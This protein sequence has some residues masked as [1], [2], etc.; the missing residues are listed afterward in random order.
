METNGDDYTK[1]SKRNKKWHALNLPCPMTSHLDIIASAHWLEEE[2]DAPA[3]SWHYLSARQ[4]NRLPSETSGT[5]LT[6]RR[7]FCCKFRSS[8]GKTLTWKP[9]KAP[10]QSSKSMSGFHINSGGILNSPTALNAPI[11]ARTCQ[12]KDKSRK[13]LMLALWTCAKLLQLTLATINSITPASQTHARRLQRP[14]VPR[15]SSLRHSRSSQDPPMGGCYTQDSPFPQVCRS[16]RPFPPRS[17]K[18][19]SNCL[20]VCLLKQVEPTPHFFFFFFFC[21]SGSCDAY[22]PFLR[23]RC[24]RCCFI[25]SI[26]FFFFNSSA[27]SY[28]YSPSS[29]SEAPPFSAFSSSTP[30]LLLILILALLLP[31][32]LLLLLHQTPSISNL[33]KQICGKKK[34]SRNCSI[35]SLLLFLF[36]VLLQLLCFFRCLLFSFS[37]LPPPT[38]LLLHQLPSNSNLKKRICSPPKNKNLSQNSFI[39]RLFFFNPSASSD[40]YYSLSP[41]PDAPHFFCSFIN[42][43]NPATS[44]TDFAANEFY[45]RAAKNCLS[46]GRFRHEKL[47]QSSSR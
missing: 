7:F 40:T 9:N 18:P 37:C 29:A 44:Q 21:S 13:T 38:L 3:D 14:N 10:S 20:P 1:A 23:S 6:S 41:A 33:K 43:I 34:L 28:P 12:K 45:K 4:Q 27:S 36:F 19:P 8:I 16:S 2:P 11:A 5:G 42:S 17:S 47:R 15:E 30:L 31:I 46:C 35:F 32:L 39:F 22:S 25:N 24:C 26:F